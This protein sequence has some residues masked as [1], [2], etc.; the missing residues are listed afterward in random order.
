MRIWRNNNHHAIRRRRARALLGERRLLAYEK[1]PQ[2]SFIEN[3]AAFL[4]HIMREAGGENEISEQCCA[5][6]SLIV[7]GKHPYLAEGRSRAALK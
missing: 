4:Q 1:K 3:Q 2:A 7:F 6:A 5:H